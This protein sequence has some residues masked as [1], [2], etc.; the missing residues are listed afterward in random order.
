MKETSSYG[1]SRTE[2][3]K[4]GCS[5]AAWA[6]GSLPWGRH[7]FIVDVKLVLIEMIFGDV[8]TGLVHFK[9]EELFM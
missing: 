1:S 7:Q 6:M 4:D 3:R 5:D 2:G 8:W 9:Q